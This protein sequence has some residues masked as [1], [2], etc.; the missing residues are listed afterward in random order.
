MFFYLPLVSSCSLILQG[1][2][3]MMTF[4]VG[5]LFWLPGAGLGAL[6]PKLSF[7]IKAIMLYCNFLFTALFPS[8]LCIWGLG[9][10]HYL[11]GLHYYNTYLGDC[12]SVNICWTLHW[13]SSPHLFLV[14]WIFSAFYGNTVEELP[15]SILVLASYFWYSLSSD[16]PPHP[17]PFHHTHPNLFPSCSPALIVS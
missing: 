1:L 17:F 6:L 2:F 11:P 7:P 16:F 4:L 13:F 15:V 14:P 10:G 5:R 9:A 12:S 3:L 8:W